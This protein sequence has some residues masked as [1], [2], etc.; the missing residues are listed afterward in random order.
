MINCKKE[1]LEEVEA[2]GRDVLCAQLVY[3][4]KYEDDD[5]TI[6][7]LKV[8]HETEDTQNFL[9]SIDFMYDNGFGGQI[10]FGNIWYAD[11]SWSERAEYD[12]SEWWEHKTMPEIPKELL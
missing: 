8:G 4:D 9:K 7:N 3:G 1:F 12:G 2:N 5:I 6:Y 10:L 11:G